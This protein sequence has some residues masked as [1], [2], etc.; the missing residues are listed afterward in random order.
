MTALALVEVLV[1]YQPYD[2]RAFLV[3][4]QLAVAHIVA[5]HIAPEHNA[6]LHT[7]ALTPL[8]ALRGLSAFLLRY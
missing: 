2:L 1:K 8:D 3:D 7:S 6:L 4:D 5:K